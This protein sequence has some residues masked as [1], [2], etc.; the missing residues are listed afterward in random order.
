MSFGET[1][2]STDKGSPI[3]LYRFRYGPGDNDVYC[4]TDHEKS[5]T[6]DELLDDESTIART[7][8]PVAIDRDAI[9]KSGKLS[10]SDLNVQIDRK[11]ELT[12]LFKDYPP[13]SI[14][15]LVI[16]EGHFTDDEQQFLVSWS[17]RVLSFQ[18]TGDIAEFTCKPISTSLKQIMI[19]RH[20]QYGCAH[21]LYGTMCRA[22]RAD[23]TVEKIV[24]QVNRSV[25]RCQPG[26]DAGLAANYAGG[27]VAWTLSDGRTIE[28]T[29]ISVNHDTGFIVLAGP[30]LGMEVGETISISLGC[31]HTMEDCEGVFDNI[32]NFGGFP[33]IPLKSPIGLIN[34][35][36]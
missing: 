7:Y 18:F 34:N 32:L 5:V 22:V 3:N 17:G 13:S 11:A 8:D 31:K 20:Y 15:T 21:I 23:H 1:E 24:L 30:A 12:N 33:W 27:I 28:R 10:D 4:Y 19:R 25:I 35:Y 36:Y 14:V 9:K 2:T 29:I 26:W 6:I 16:Q